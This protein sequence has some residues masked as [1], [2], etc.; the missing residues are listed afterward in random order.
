MGFI[1]K[2]FKTKKKKNE[3]FLLSEYEKGK[4]LQVDNNI[5]NK[6]FL[7]NREGY[8]GFRGQQEKNI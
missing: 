2:L 4:I 7:N 3:E 1:K 8:N 5:N 6:E